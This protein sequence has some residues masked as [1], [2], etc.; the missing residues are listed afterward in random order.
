MTLIIAM[1]RMDFL[2]VMSKVDFFIN[3]LPSTP[4][5]KNLIGEKELST[6]KPTAFFINIG[7]GDTVVEDDLVNVLENKGI[8]GA[9]I[10]VFSSSSYV[11]PSSP[12]HPDSP[13]LSLD[14]VILTPHVAGLT[15]RY[16]EKECTL[17]L[18]NL[19]K[20][21]NGRDLVNEVFVEELIS[22]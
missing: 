6:L 5:T 3:I 14:N 11:N 15:K 22:K 19:E 13:F 21:G 7:R 8:Y 12:L 4:E 20:F 16:W 2:K 9:G 18:E 10:D 17:F 1:D